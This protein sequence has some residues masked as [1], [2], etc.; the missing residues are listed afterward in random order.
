MST[1]TQTEAKTEARPN[2]GQRGGSLGRAIASAA[3][4][5]SS[6]AATKRAVTYLRVSSAAQADKDYDSEGFSLPAQRAA[7]ERKAASLGAQVVE[8]FVER[9]ESGT[10]TSGRRALTAML[11]RLSEGD[12]DYVIVHKVDRLARKRA[13]DSAI[14][15]AIRDAGA[16]LVSV[17]ENIDETPSGML[18]HGIMAS[19]AEFY[20]MNL[21]AEVM[22]G[23]TEKAK[24]GGTPGRPPIGYLNVRE[25]VDGYEIR[26]IGLDPERD[27]LVTLAFRLYATGDYSLSELA[28][29]LEAKGLRNRPRRGQPVT[30]LGVNRLSALLRHDYYIG[31]V[32]Y[33]GLV[34]KGRHPSLTDEAT[35]QRVQE[36][37]DSQRTSGERCWRHHHY[38]RGSVFCGECDGRLIY[39]RA[40]GRGGGTYE[41]FVCAGRQEGTCSQPHHR[42]EAVERAI[43]DEYARV[44]LSGQ[45]REKIRA[46]VRAYVAALDG[47]AEPEREQIE[48]ALKSIAAQ[49]KKL[50][51]AHYNDL[52]SSE[53]FTEEQQ[54]LRRERVAAEQRQGELQAD[55]RVTLDRLELA[56]GLT[57]RVQAAYS[58]AEPQ[59]RRIFNQAIF[60]RIW[61]DREEVARRE[62]AT[63]FRDLL[64]EDLAGGGPAHGAGPERVNGE[65][66]QVPDRG[67]ASLGEA[68][69]GGDPVLRRAFAGQNEASTALLDRGGSNVMTM[70]RMRGLEPPR[71]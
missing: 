70:V 21:A 51:Q 61:I 33:A 64:A 54:R 62:L 49:E 19:I 53:L 39:T 5:A 56:L 30:A 43:E 15:Q 35:F 46:E 58:G 11:A 40:T 36:V 12:I 3:V 2:P 20:S 57:D 67:A 66:E 1:M 24:R 23:T 9:G 27:W 71:A 38:L 52:I 34:S 26:T 60:A 68:G 31:V 47:K 6:G 25:V 42:V 37:L 50:L 55:H 63:P 44:Q 8:S 14:L 17:S 41:Y 65:T 32:T 29:I 69:L 13:D 4:V 18:L 59:T 16:T 22:K 48:T 28:A 10:S 7:C 45:R